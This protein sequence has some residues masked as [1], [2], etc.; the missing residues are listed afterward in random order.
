MMQP[1]YVHFCR[2]YV[3]HLIDIVIIITVTNA[4]IRVT[5]SQICFRGSLRSQIITIIR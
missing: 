1:F 3:T 5:V 4:L 2:K